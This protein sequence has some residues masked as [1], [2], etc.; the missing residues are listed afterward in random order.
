MSYKIV[1]DSCLDCNEELK[2]TGKIT[3]VPL[4]LEVGD[5]SVIDDETFD[6]AAFIKA[7]RE[8]KDCPR[9]ACPSPNA[10]KEAYEGEEERVY[11]ITLS[12]HLSG[13]FNS[14]MVGK[15]LYEEEFE[16]D[17][18][19]IA[20]FSSDS[21]CCGEAVIAKKIMELEEKQLSFDEICAQTADF[22]YHM[23]TLFVIE[24][25][26]TLKKNGRLT[27]LAAIL[28]TA[29]NIK[30]LMGADHGVIIK[31][32]QTRGMNKA[33]KK[34]IEKVAATAEH[35]EERVLGISH[36]NCPDRAAYVKEE[37]SKRVTFKEIYITNTAGVGTMYAND[38][39]IVVSF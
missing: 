37:I 31:L 3:I 13:S 4:T 20:V 30:P 22:I 14:A 1:G 9:S 26:D 39:G 6:Q 11:C 21:A 27:G 33:L 29:L 18:K 28:A 15:D 7:V 38:G 5:L 32:D 34:L 10:F 35:P 36:C 2:Q 25:L 17:G 24:T 23:T 19:Q 16:G 12:K 8:A